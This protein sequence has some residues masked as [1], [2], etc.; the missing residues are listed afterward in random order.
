MI[1]SVLTLFSAT[2]LLAL[3]PGPDNIFVLT[4]SITNGKIAGLAT[5]A[6]LLT[7]CIVHTTL[8][9]FGM[10][11][12]I[13]NNPTLYLSIKVVGALYLIYLA[14]KIYASGAELEQLPETRIINNWVLYRQGVIMNLLNPKVTL[15]FLAL[16]PGFIWDH[17]SNIVIQ[18]YILG[19]TFIFSSFIVFG[20]IA[21]LAGML[22]KNFLKNQNVLVLL[23]WFQIVVFIGIALFIII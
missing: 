1:E 5:T 4:Q 3:S 17:S 20:A 22:T 11:V 6:G 12:I 15:F 13:V 23:K 9:A 19:F 10:S 21:M 18:F 16:F 2:I 7:G 14:Y 8:V